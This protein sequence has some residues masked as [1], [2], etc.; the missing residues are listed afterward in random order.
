MKL[1]YRYSPSEAYE[2]L[3][4]DRKKEVFTKVYSYA[5]KLRKGMTIISVD[6]VEEITNF[7]VYY[8]LHLEQAELKYGDLFHH[9]ISMACWKA[10]RLFSDRIKVR[11]REQKIFRPF[12]DYERLVGDS[13]RDGNEEAELELAGAPCTSSAERGSAEQLS[14]DL[15][16]Y[17]AEVSENET[18]AAAQSQTAHHAWTIRLEAAVGYSREM[19]SDA[20]RVLDL[21]LLEGQSVYEFDDETRV[22]L[23]AQQIESILRM[24]RNRI[25]KIS[26]LINETLRELLQARAIETP[27]EN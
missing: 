27:K 2:R 13:D 5:L 1:P 12:A 18:A 26:K 10:G 25:S 22:R 24:D 20:I 4:S 14:P 16:D 21:M 3:S 9:M 15:V 23:H 8:M 11:I 6:D 7:A 17:G 19:R